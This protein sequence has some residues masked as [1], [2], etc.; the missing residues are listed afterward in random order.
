M[1]IRT[2]IVD[3]DSYAIESL[4]YVMKQIPELEI[5]G[6][7]TNPKE[8]IAFIQQE[9]PDLMFLDIRMPEMSGFELLDQIESD[10]MEVIFVTG[11]NQYAINALRYS[12]LDYL[13]KPVTLHDLSASVL[14][15]HQRNE[16][17]MIQ[18]RLLNLKK[19]LSVKEEDFDL[20]L[21]TKSEG[22][23]KFRAADIIRCEAD[24][25]YTVIYATTE[26]KFTASKTL[27][28]LENMLASNQFVRI[29]KSHL[30]NKR[31]IKSL[32]RNLEM[33]LSDE[34]VLPV[35]KRRI[36]EVRKFLTA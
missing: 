4:K 1:T 6:V 10:S 26:R 19:N 25:N 17:I 22:E 27:G 35:S 9:K 18:S 12:A 11:H 24:S 21:L 3:D 20:V 32:N 2:I 14:R 33:T 23:K 28:D 8:S 15:Y 36:Q 7:F 34:T 13:L 31:F 30:I 5:I 29:H 16:R